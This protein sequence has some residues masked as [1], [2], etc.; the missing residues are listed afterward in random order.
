MPVPIELYR[1]QFLNGAIKTAQI[2]V[3]AGGTVLFQFLNG[4]IKTR[5][6]QLAKEILLHFNSSMVR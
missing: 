3:P 1:F 5:S 4:A 2:V 6:L